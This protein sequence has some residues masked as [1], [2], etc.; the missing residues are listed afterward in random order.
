MDALRRLELLVLALEILRPDAQ[1]EIADIALAVFD[2]AARERMT[3]KLMADTRIKAMDFRNGVAMDLVLAEEI[4]ASWVAAG[5]TMLGTAENYVECVFTV[6]SA[7]E[8]YALTIQ[9]PGKLTPHEARRQAEAERD[10]AQTALG[11]YAEKLLDALAEFGHDPAQ[12]LA[13]VEEMLTGAREQ[14]R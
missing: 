12:A 7:G 9:R 8:R 6:G 14:E 4:A 2:E 1:D 13:I 5:R 10:Q 3:E 11:R